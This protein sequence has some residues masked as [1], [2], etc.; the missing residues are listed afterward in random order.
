MT[1]RYLYSA[2][3]ALL[4]LLSAPLQAQP[5]CTPD[6]TLASIGLYP[7]SLPTAY[8]GQPYSQTIQAVLP[9]DTAILGF[10]F[11]FCSYEIVSLTP[12]PST[13]GLSYQCDQPN[14]SYQVNHMTVNGLN[15]GCVV[16]SGTPTGTL[17][18]I[19]VNI[20]AVIGTYNAQLDTCIASTNFTLPYTVNFRILDTTSSAIE[21]LRELV[22]PALRPN[23]AQA[24]AE[25]NFQL[26]FAAQVR[27]ELLDP[28]GRVIQVMENQRI[29]PGFH[30]YPFSV[31]DLSAGLYLVRLSL[32]EG[33]YVFTEKLLVSGR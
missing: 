21:E 11:A 13:R 23:P 31:G 12:N 33:T 9:T 32:D 26:P 22:N 28:M 15:Y 6:T 17:D 14:C 29:Q 30:S 19:L 3:A 10:N 25:L 27:A 16:L 18:S 5:P 4:I 2:L 7:D 20:K 8:V 1:Q 24:G